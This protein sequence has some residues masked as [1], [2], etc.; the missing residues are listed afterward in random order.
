MKLYIVFKKNNCMFWGGDHYVES[1]VIGTVV[2]GRKR[3]VQV[4]K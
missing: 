3:V 2:E 1:L 4:S